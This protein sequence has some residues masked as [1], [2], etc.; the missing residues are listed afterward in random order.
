[1]VNSRDTARPAI[2]AYK[3]FHVM[4]PVRIRPFKSRL[5]THEKKSSQW[6]YRREQF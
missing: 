2:E 5:V 6:V 3:W 1:M 4:K